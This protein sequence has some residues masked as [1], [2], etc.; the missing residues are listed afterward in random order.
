MSH[1]HHP[2]SRAERRQQRRR[3]LLRRWQQWR[4]RWLFDDPKPRRL[5]ELE[6]LLLRRVHRFARSPVFCACSL[7][8]PRNPRR[9]YGDGTW[10]E[11]RTDLRLWEELCEAGLE[12]LMPPR[13]FRFPSRV[14]GTLRIS[15]FS[16]LRDDNEE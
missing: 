11:A 15:P 16:E 8:Y 14:R 6:P 2:Q 13:R 7:C 1:A 9:R 3:V 4:T 12:D 10:L 5:A